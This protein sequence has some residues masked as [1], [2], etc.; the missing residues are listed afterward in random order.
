MKAKFGSPKAKERSRS[1]RKLSFADIARTAMRQK[2][3]FK[4]IVNKVILKNQRL[5]FEAYNKPSSQQSVLEQLSQQ[6]VDLTRICDVQARTGAII[7]GLNSQ[8]QT[9]EGR[10]KAILSQH[11]H[12]RSKLTEL[13]AD[14][15][16]IGDLDQVFA[17]I[18]D[19]L[20]TDF[21]EAH[22]QVFEGVDRQPFSSRCSEYKQSIQIKVLT[23]DMTLNSID[24]AEAANPSFQ[25]LGGNKGMVNNRQNSL[26]LPGVPVIRS[27]DPTKTEL[28]P[29]K[30]LPIDEENY[31]SPKNA[32]H[33]QTPKQS[34]FEKASSPKVVQ[35]PT[36]SPT[37]RVTTPSNHNDMYREVLLRNRQKFFDND[38]VDHQKLIEQQHEIV[39]KDFVPVA[40]PVARPVPPKQSAFHRIEDSEP[41]QLQRDVE[42]PTSSPKIAAHNFI[43][44]DSDHQLE[45][46]RDPQVA[47]PGSVHPKPPPDKKNNKYLK[48]VKLFEMVQSGSAKDKKVRLGPHEDEDSSDSSRRSQSKWRSRKKPSTK[49]KSNLVDDSDDELP[50]STDIIPSLDS[51]QSFFDKDAP[52]PP[53][54]KQRLKPAN[55]KRKTGDSESLF[56]G[57]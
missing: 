18:R 57:L 53:P 1:P 5:K 16:S 22:P 10:H 47:A 43:S 4:R 39:L 25:S 32:I 31:E 24:D 27:K 45:V 54:Q 8:I 30:Q 56:N 2:H 20:D 51:N 38:L 28:S 52:S 29:I 49:R 14:R 48:R 3:N 21:P 34:I 13:L 23:P 11:A 41:P 6:A 36:S 33:S 35:S 40:H 19:I 42:E 17:R 12:I 26:D 37:I 9:L 55:N 44:C 50:F 46:A 7:A 15:E